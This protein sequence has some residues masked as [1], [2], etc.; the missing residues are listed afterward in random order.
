MAQPR[1]PNSSDDWVLQL[2]LTELRWWLLGIPAPGEASVNQDG[3]S[4]EIHDF[5]AERLA[6]QHQ[7]ARSRHSG[8]R[9]RS[10]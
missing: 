6:R 2:P 4:G 8:L 5:T 9:C 10:G 7:F 1:A 3:A